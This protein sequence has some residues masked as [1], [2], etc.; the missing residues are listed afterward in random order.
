MHPGDDTPTMSPCPALDAD[1]ARTDARS[2]SR[3][4]TASANDTASVPPRRD[5][6]P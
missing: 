4:V 2:R 6:G 3:T 1:V 5:E